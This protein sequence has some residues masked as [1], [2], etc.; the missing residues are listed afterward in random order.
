M[1][2]VFEVKAQRG[3]IESVWACPV[4]G[5][6]EDGGRRMQSV[7]PRGR[8]GGLTVETLRGTAERG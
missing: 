4:E 8:G 1:L 5:Q 2:D 3:Q 6:R 7:E